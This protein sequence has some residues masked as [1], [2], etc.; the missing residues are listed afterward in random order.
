MIQRPTALRSRP[1][2]DRITAAL[3][4][5]DVMQVQSIAKELKSS[6]A[7]IAPYCDKLIH[8]AED[9]DF[10]GILDLARKLKS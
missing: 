7:A 4:M 9:F 1:R 5:G 3:E 8:L 10:D 2:V 6:N